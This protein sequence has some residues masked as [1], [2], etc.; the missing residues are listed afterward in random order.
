MVGSGPAFKTSYDNKYKQS[1]SFASDTGRYKNPLNINKHTSEELGKAVKVDPLYELKNSNITFNH[2][3]L[4]A[5]NCDTRE[6]GSREGSRQFQRS[7]TNQRTYRTETK[8]LDNSKSALNK[9]QII[10]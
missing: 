5:P 9:T 1:T 6:S 10:N 3:E 2:P 7:K 4:D 8:R